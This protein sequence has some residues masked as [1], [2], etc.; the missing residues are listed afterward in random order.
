[1]QQQRHSLSLLVSCRMQRRP[2][3][4]PITLRV[5][6]AQAMLMMTRTSDHRKAWRSAEARDDIAPIRLSA[7]TR[8]CLEGR[9]H[10]NM[11]VRDQLL[12]RNSSGRN[13]FVVTLS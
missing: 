8:W 2:N 1:M 12:C 11:A 6:F 13:E 5:N 9:H 7:T 4:R 3:R 10:R